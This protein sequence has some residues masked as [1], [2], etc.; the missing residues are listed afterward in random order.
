MRAASAVRMIG[1]AIAAIGGGP[2]AL[3]VGTLTVGAPAVRKYWQPI[4][5]WLS[6][7]FNAIRTAIGP[8]MS[9]LGAALAPLKPAWD[10][11]SNTVGKAWGWVMKLLQPVNMTS[12]QLKA[13]GESG[14]S[15]GRIVGGVMSFIIGRI[16]ATVR[17]VTWLIGAISKV[18]KMATSLPGIGLVVQGAQTLGIGAP[19]AT[20][21]IAPARGRVAPV[22]RTAAI[23]SRGGKSVTDSSQHVY[24]ITQQPGESGEALAKRIEDERRRREAVDRRS[25]LVDVA[26]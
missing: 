21:P 4:A 3:A 25:S 5:A 13:A 22:A 20:R 9:E 6:G 12:E 7:Y 1:T 14:A 15:F 11:I 19:S 18:G 2:I 23:V 26:T 17:A 8:A 10:S 24:H 16:T